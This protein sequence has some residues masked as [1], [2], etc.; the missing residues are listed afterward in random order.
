MP[1]ILLNYINNNYAFRHEGIEI[2]YHEDAFNIREHLKTGKDRSWLEVHHAQ[3]A[4]KMTECQ[5]TKF[6]QI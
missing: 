5:A 6:F 1:K 2:L 3:K 4:S